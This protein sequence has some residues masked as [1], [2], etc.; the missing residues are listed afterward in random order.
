MNSLFFSGLKLGI[1][2]LGG[3]APDEE[4]FH[5]ALDWLREQ[6]ATV[7]SFYDPAGKHLRFGGTDD[8]RAAQLH[9]AA[10]DP[11]VDVILALRGG[12]G[13]SRL[14]PLLYLDL[15]AR[16]KKPVVGHSDVTA[17][18]LALLNKGAG[19]FAGPMVC[20]DFTRTERSAF[21][22]Q[23]FRDCLAG[24]EHAVNFSTTDAAGLDVIGTLW[25]GN[26]AM[27]NHLVGTPYFP[28]LENGI[29]FIEDVN[30]HPYRVERMLLQLH[31]AGALRQRAIV[32]GDFS[33]YRLTEYDNGYDFSATL[34]YLRGVLNVPLVTGL[35]F[36]H[37]KDKVTLAVGSQARLVCD[38]SQASLSMRG[39]ASLA[40]LRQP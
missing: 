12:Y 14:L 34:A 40:C 13:M 29:L 15:L 33:G 37:T 22:L 32:F 38:G 39:Y 18:Q 1:V 25:G 9:A 28:R 26:L 27:L 11:G 7:R 17:L 31:Y 24:P 36:G 35:P 6:G 20:D 23:H 16:C 8:A 5:R 19:S 21:G 10:V 3:Y 30:E 2:A 4:A